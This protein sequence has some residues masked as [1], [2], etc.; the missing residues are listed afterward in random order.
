MFT[1]HSGNSFPN[2]FWRLRQ[3]NSQH[4]TCEFRLDLVVVAP[5]RH[6]DESFERTVFAL[7][8]IIAL[9][10]LFSFVSLLRLD[11]KCIVGETDTSI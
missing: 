3:L 1:S 9:S 2:D 6:L 10:L 11:D 5:D 8:E 4:A 7:M